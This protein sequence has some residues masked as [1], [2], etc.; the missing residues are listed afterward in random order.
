MTATTTLRKSN[1]D[2]MEK[3]GKLKYSH[4]AFTR[5]YISRK[6]TDPEA[7]PYNGRYGKGYIVDC[8]NYQSTSYSHRLYYILIS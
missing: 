1:L 5:G 7:T 6:I 2:D 4:S 3:E 8:P